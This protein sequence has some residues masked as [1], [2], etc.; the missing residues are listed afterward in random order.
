MLPLRLP[1][2]TLLLF[3]ALLPAQEALVRRDYVVLA[4]IAADDPFDAAAQLLARHHRAPIVRFDPAQLAPVRTALLAAA[5]RHVALVLRPEQIDF[6][7]VRAFLQLA[8]GLDDD[9]FVD[10]AFGY[11]TG[12][13][14]ADAEALATRGS[15]RV[16]QAAKA[17]ALAAGG[18][19]KSSVSTVPHLLRRNRL[20]SLHLLGAGDENAPDVAFWREHLA[21]L[22]GR[23]V[24]TFAGH[25]YP[26][27]V[28]GGPSFAELVGLDLGGT[29][30][31]N[32]A[33]YTGVTQ[34]WFEDDWRNGVVVEQQV[35]LDES[36]CLA[37]L[38]TGVVGYTAYVCP[39]PAGPELD[40]D[41][42][43]LVSEGLS[44]GEARRRDYDKTVLGFLGFGAERLQL[45]PVVN[46]AKLSPSRDAVRDIMLEGATGGIV[47]GDPACVPFVAR[48][49]QAPVSITC[50][51][52]DGEYRIKARVAASDLFLHCSDPTA[53]WGKTMAM[54]VYGRVPIHSDV[55]DFVVDQL[56]VGD[57][58]QPTRVLWA[59]EEDHGRRFLQ[60]KV[61][62][63]RGENLNGELLLSARALKTKDATVAKRLGGEVRRPVVTSTDVR[64]RA[65]EPFLELARSR[66]VAREALQD[67]LDASALQLG[68]EGAPADALAKLTARG[69][70]GFHAVCV[71]LEVGHVHL[72]TVKLLQAT[73]RPGEE[74]RLFA[75]ASQPQLPQYG[76][77]AVLE[78]LGCADTPEVRTFLLARLQDRSD[79]GHFMSAAQGLALLGE[80]RAVEPIDARLRAFEPGWDGVAP[81]LIEVLGT[82]GGAA[83]VR[84]LEALGSND[85]CEHAKHVVAALQRLDPE[86]A[87]RVR[88][89]RK[90]R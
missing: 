2:V 85:Q 66:G 68:V 50:E 64:A 63:P 23:D 41:M 12:R 15:T 33:C 32:V 43:A 78:G 29:V 69:S 51:G 8:T 61:N 84:A 59:I 14:A 19:P 74:K 7:F 1:V 25:G 77:W 30:V 65:V 40:T 53:T 27:S 24:V 3:T 11:I 28:V 36:F 73:W 89:A 47:F 42:T 26:K 17:I 21:K 58:V 72:H 67:A 88:A 62:F 55:A 57:K 56:K 44:L 31:L 49:M 79:A 83:A 13:T 70:D 22:H 48:P 76:M 54:R 71:L 81:Y 60:W 9:P 18:C 38:R 35:P 82:L 45:A 4:A 10:F 80:R 52:A 34:R 90:L 86:A 75:L 39:R 87:A 5:P 46:G 6:P 16:P 20:E 37:V